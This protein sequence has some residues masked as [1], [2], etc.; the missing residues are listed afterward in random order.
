MLR[1]PVPLKQLLVAAATLVAGLSAVS[2]R[3]SAQ[4]AAPRPQFRSTVDTVHLDVSVLD[5]S[6]RPVR[7]L[8]PADFT[9]LEDGKPQQVAVFQAI[10]IPDPEP[11]ST[12]WVRDVAPDVG[13]NDG[14]QERRLFLIIMDDVTIQSNGQA[15]T[16]AR[17]IARG[18]IDKLG[19]SDLAA[20][21]FTRDNRAAQD[22]TA[23][24]VRL[25]AAAGKFTV[26]F[27]DMGLFDAETQKAIAGQDDFSYMASV[28]V[29]E[30]AVGV[31]ASMPDRR[32][33]I[34]YIGQGQPVNPD[35][36]APQAPGLPAGGGTSGLMQGALAARIRM[37]L[38]HVFQR[39]RRANVNVYT[40][41]ACGLRTPGVSAGFLP[42][43][44]VP[45]FEVEYLRTLAENTGGRAVVDT[46]DVGPGI[47]A[48]FEENAS[49]YLIGYRPAEVRQDGKFRRL[50]VRVSRPDVEVRTRT[51]YQAEKA[52]DLR[53]RQA[54]I[55][56]S[57]LGAALAGVLP[58]SDLPLRISTVAVALPGRRESAVGVAV[59]VRQ[60]IRETSGRAVERVD[61]QVS[62][63]GVEGK[64]FGSRRLQADVAIRAG[65]AGLAEYEVLTRIDLRPGRYQLRI[66]GHVGSLS[67]SGSL[68]SDVDVPDV[69]RAPVSLSA[70]VL[71]AS[72]GPPVSPRNALEA[73]L[74]VVPTTRRTFAPADRVTAFLRVY[75]GRT[76]PLV[77]TP[78]RVQI[79]DDRGAL[80]MSRAQE[81]AA[82]R[83]TP[84]RSA[85][86]LVDL[87]VARL[88]DG[89]YLLT[90]AADR[91]GAL[92]RRDVRFRVAR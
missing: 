5:R 39:A 12:A 45:G 77:A 59:G 35:L 30:K 46:D 60:P 28:D 86:I 91:G 55:A 34:V 83:F 16:R 29:L 84:A 11:P 4:P 75:Q 71:S 9:I 7:G 57:P 18:V 26:G 21:V 51:G 82:A 14:L 17:D 73:F 68:Y 20:L 10:D 25:L 64:P 42:P 72:P 65:A 50:D 22:F 49:Y 48:I 40:L 76:T 61:L 66:A 74:P 15:I 8:M 1:L 52:S 85:D 63:F 44:C 41:D 78:V 31:L 58:K 33:A 90:V 70:P 67:T 36:A 24:R 27:R 79:A 89:E 6:R 32:K 92:A 43:T 23:D 38:D 2:A 87:P 54:A 53:R 88:A 62:A 81:I 3:Q 56:A 19:P 13:S 47:A 80:V 69:T 37:Q